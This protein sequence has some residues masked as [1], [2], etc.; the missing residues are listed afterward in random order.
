MTE[1][2]ELAGPTEM[3]GP[4]E[5]AALSELAGPPELVEPMELVEGTGLTELTGP[6]ALTVSIVVPA[7]NEAADIVECLTRLRRDFPDCE[8]ILADGGSTDDTA[9]LA[10]SVVTVLRTGRGR[11]TQMNAGA[12]HTSGDVLWFVH[13]DTVIAPEASAELRAALTDPSVV[14]GGL[15]LRFDRRSRS[16][17]LIA[18]TSNARARRLHQ[19]FGDQAMFVRRSVFTEM[20]GFPAL[21]LM[22]DLEFSRRLAR[23]GGLVLLPASSTASARRFAE[24]GTWRMVAFMQC[25]KLAYFA[26]VSPEYI[27]RR[28]E[29]GPPRL[30]RRFGEQAHG[31]SE[32]QGNHRTPLAGQEVSSGQR[33]R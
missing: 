3:A 13:A 31:R 10:A 15:S 1:L 6:T 18:R 11:A 27:R 14:G 22:E 7:F 30:A 9:E 2:A 25:L 4:T 12:A 8:L 32:S 21:P 17:D 33:N 5:L 20:G 16:L 26:G 23:R 29:K 19:I 28:Y 24:H